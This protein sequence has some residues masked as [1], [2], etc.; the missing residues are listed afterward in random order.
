MMAD[1]QNHQLNPDQ[2]RDLL[3]PYLD[4]EVT[5]EERALVE[6]ALAVSAELQGELETLRRTMALVAALPPVPAPRPFTLTE[7][8]VRGI[9]VPAPKSLFGLPSWV[10]GWAALAATLLCVLAAGGLFWNMQFGGGSRQ[11]AAPAAEVANAPQLAATVTPEK[12][13]QPQLRPS[14]LPKRR[15]RLPQLMRKVWLQQ[16][17]LPRRKRLR[18]L[19]KVWQ[20]RP[21]KRLCQPR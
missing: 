5:D 18:P 12:F 6:Q 4:G 19:K 14:P 8:D 17:Q 1:N 11:A 2:I 16:K 9:A 15:Q 3:S 7:A 20:M 13:S 21:K 10:K